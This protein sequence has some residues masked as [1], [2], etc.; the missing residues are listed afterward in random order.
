M[1]VSPQNTSLGPDS[2]NRV[3][4]AMQPPEADSDVNLARTWP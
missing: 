2:F 1:E 4:P 3:G